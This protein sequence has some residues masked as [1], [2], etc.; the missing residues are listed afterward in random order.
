MYIVSDIL[1][2]FSRKCLL[3]V[4]WQHNYITNIYHLILDK[5]MKG[6]IIIYFY[7][8]IQIKQLHI[9]HCNVVI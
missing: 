1:Y 9:Y 6:K 7:N 5:A 3:C 2:N 8:L 4:P